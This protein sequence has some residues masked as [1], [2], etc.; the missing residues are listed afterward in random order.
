M[1]KTVK[2][3]AF[4]NVAKL[5]KE[6]KKIILFLKS[7]IKKGSVNIKSQRSRF[8]KTIPSF[9]IAKNTLEKNLEKR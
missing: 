7:I 3:K 9:F 6:S 8:L 4:I 2:I 1:K 5:F